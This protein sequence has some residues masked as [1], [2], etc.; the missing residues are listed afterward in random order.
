M[1]DVVGI[2]GD[3]DDSSRRLSEIT[4]VINGIAFQTNILALNAAVEAARA[5]E[6][7]S[8]SRFCSSPCEGG[9]GEGVLKRSLNEFL[10]TPPAFCAMFFFLLLY[11]FRRFP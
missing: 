10:T 3:I 6:Q 8:R 7:G 2:M 5:G 4:S 1:T 11:F 9:G